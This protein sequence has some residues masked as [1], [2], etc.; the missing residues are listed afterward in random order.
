MTQIVS[1][2]RLIEMLKQILEV[3]DIDIKNYAIESLIE[4]LTEGIYDEPDID[5][6]S[7]NSIE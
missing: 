6:G 1:K 7:Q 4:T 2:E 5:K 3:P